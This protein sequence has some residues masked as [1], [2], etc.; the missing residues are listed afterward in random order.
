MDIPHEKLIIQRNAALDVL[1]VL[2]CAMV[3]LMHSPIPNIGTPGF[4]LSGLSYLTSPCIGLFFMASGALLLPN[5]TE[6]AAHF[7]TKQFLCKR[8]SKIALP[9]IIW[10]VFSVLL[11]MIGIKNA[12]R[13]VLWFMYTLAGL[14]LLTPILSRWLY[15]A[16]KA[17]IEL[18]LCL[19]F[20]TL[21]VPFIKLFI[22]INESDT[23]CLYYFHGYIG[24]YVWGGYLNR[25]T[26]NKLQKYIYIFAF[27][28]FSICI[29]LAVLGL[30]IEIDFY[31]LFWYLSLPVVLMCTFWWFL[32]HHIQKTHK[33][34]TILS[35]LSFGIY[36]VHILVM[37][38]IIWKIG[39]ISTICGVGNALS[40]ILQI[41]ITTI[42]SFGISAILCYLI[43]KTSIG[44][45]LIG[46]KKK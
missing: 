30:H 17:E 9:T 20:V 18:Y 43:S 26:F 3:V 37:R 34:V 42:A 15:Q 46:T 7:N 33:M 2:A 36:L 38:N 4:V 10:T 29:P 14:Y 8:F 27:V 11:E 13:D 22:S 6:Q 28:V 35:K 39:G 23:S 19:W 5:G 41:I 45:I 16:S 1:R 40:G 31:N 12:E 25:F 44:G 24:Y 21:L 32:C